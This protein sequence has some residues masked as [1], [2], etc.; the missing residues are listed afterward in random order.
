MRAIIFS[1]FFFPLIGFAQVPQTTSTGNLLK[2]AKAKGYSFE[3]EDMAISY[4]P[5]FVKDAK[6]HLVFSLKDI[7]KN[8]KSIPVVDDRNDPDR[9]SK[10]VKQFDQ[11]CG[12]I[13][14]IKA[15]QIPEANVTNKYYEYYGFQVFKIG[16]SIDLPAN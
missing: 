4:E 6:V 3:V 12:D 8:G 5:K 9:I 16:C 13:F 15:A 2:N 7:Q 11:L 1:L 14:D 10:I